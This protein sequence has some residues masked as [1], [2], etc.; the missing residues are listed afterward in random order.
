MH[1]IEAI[2]NPVTR[3]L[4]DA[5]L[6]RR[7]I[8]RRAVALPS[9]R[10]RF[11]CK[12]KPND[13]RYLLL[14]VHHPMCRASRLLQNISIMSSAKIVEAP[15]VAPASY[16]T[17]PPPHHADNCFKSPWASAAADIPA[18]T[19]ERGFVA[20]IKAGFTKKK[21]A[22]LPGS[23]EIP[24]VQN[25]TFRPG[26]EAA[27]DEIVY[28]WLGHAANHLQLPTDGGKR[29]VVLTDPVFSNRWYVSWSVFDPLEWL[30]V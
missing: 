22:E 8:L 25:A 28:T 11:M 15:S 29:F 16:R 12:A 30:A 27:S 5:G 20:M 10:V 9:F 1:N 3:T 7:G 4:R 6:I 18:P 21:Q 23:A 17:T 26:H 19:G 24:E 13:T 14:H 2:L